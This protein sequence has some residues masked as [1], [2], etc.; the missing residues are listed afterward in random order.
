MSRPSWAGHAP[1]ATGSCDKHLAT[2][3]AGRRIH[4]YRR[5]A[6]SR[7]AAA[8]SSGSLDGMNV[9]VRTKLQ[10]EKKVR[11]KG[12]ERDDGFYGSHFCMALPHGSACA[13]LRGGRDPRS[14]SLF[15]L[16]PCS[17]HADWT[18]ACLQGGRG[19]C[20]HGA[21]VSPALLIM[22]CSCTVR[23]VLL[24]GRHDSLHVL[25][26]HTCPQGGIIPCSHES[27]PV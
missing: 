7:G 16:L 26:Q 14:Q 12:Y 5:A 22:V 13:C 4:G 25:V 17:L 24:A 18:C 1:N 9:T 21:F 11:T 27:H 3:L 19:P 8:V 20:S 23:I 10:R 15:S 2:R 6:C